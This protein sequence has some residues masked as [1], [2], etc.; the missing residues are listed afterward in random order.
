MTQEYINNILKKILLANV[1]IVSKKRTLGT[2]QVM[3]YDIKDFNIKILFSN[4]STH[5]K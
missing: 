2:G 5:F 4:L 1:K 3:L